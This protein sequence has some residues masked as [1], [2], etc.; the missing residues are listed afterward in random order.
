MLTHVC[1]DMHAVIGHLRSQRVAMVQSIEQLE[2]IY[3]SLL[4]SCSA[5]AQQ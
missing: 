1:A 3:T 2:F 4:S 5:L